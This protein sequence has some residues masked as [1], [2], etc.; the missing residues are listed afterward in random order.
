MN[1][2]PTKVEQRR[3]IRARINKLSGAERTAGASLICQRLREH[4]FFQRASAVLFYAPMSDEVD[5]WPL[6][7]ESLAE[8][9]IVAL[10]RFD[11]R[12]N[13]YV[14]ARLTG[15][16]E[17]LGTGAFGVREPTVTSEIVHPDAIDLALVPGVGFD[18]GGN[19]LGRGKGYYDRLLAGFGGI[20]CGIALDA[21]IAEAFTIEDHD[22]RMNW[23]L[24]PS[25]MIEGK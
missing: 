21:Q 10:P 11:P 22:I 23:V 25:R 17:E 3:E 9:K 12:S 13:I 2:Q 20:K 1:P 14:M 4:D 19:R 15:A 16:P 7:E 24:T 8:G 5:I 6:V 18:L